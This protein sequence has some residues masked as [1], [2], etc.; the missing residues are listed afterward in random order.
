VS[1]TG[2]DVSSGI[3]IVQAESGKPV[4]IPGGAWMLGA[5]FIRQ[6]PDLL[7]KD[8]A[9][10]QVLVRDFFRLEVTPSLATEGGAVISG[11]L[12]VKLAGPLAPAQYAQ[13]SPLG[14]GATGAGVAEPIGQVATIQGTVEV[15]RGDGTRARLQTGDAVYQGDV[16]ESGAN[17]SI[18]IKFADQS[19]FSLGESGRMVL[20]EMVYDPRGT[21]NKLGISLVQGAFAFVS[22]QIAK[23]APDAMT[24]STPVA[25]IGIRGTTVAGRASQEGQENTITLLNDPGGGTGEIVVSNAAG[26]IVLNVAGATVAISSINQAPPPPVILTPAQ[27]AQQYGQIVAVLTQAVQQGEQAPTQQGDPIKQFFETQNAIK[28]AYEA[29]QKQLETPT[30]PARS[31][32]RSSRPSSPRCRKSSTIFSASGS[33]N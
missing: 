2:S 32:S 30:K 3:L 5:D 8:D 24:L 29:G 7:L 16:L 28:D 18:G 33:T 26:T 27:I 31:S 11:D 22:G 25:T 12:A 17:G 23:T 15:T 21:D 4:L 14:P 19:V 20:D 10:R 1:S 6:G 9:G 13:A